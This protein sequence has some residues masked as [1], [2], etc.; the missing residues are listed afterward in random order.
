VVNIGGMIT[1]WRSMDSTSK[2]D[3]IVETLARIE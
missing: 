3:L 1:G 2:Y